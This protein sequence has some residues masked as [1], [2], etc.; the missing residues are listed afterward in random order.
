MTLHY[1][2][3]RIKN[4]PTCFREHIVTILTKVITSRPVLSNNDYSIT[5]RRY[6]NSKFS[7]GLP[8]ELC[9]V[10]NW[11][12]CSNFLQISFEI[13]IFYFV[14]PNGNQISVKNDIL[15]KSFFF[16]SNIEIKVQEGQSQLSHWG[17]VPYGGQKNRK[18]FQFHRISIFKFCG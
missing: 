17:Q 9:E 7:A 13:I 2:L 5:R 12:S 11:S 8:D 15:Q 1:L 14:V 3:F 6:G 10:T 18:L 4:E 16:Y